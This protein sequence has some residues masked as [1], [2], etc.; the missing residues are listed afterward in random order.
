MLILPYAKAFSRI[1]LATKMPQ[2]SELLKIPRAGDRKVCA[3]IYL[4]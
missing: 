4:T 2:Y 1:R 3:N